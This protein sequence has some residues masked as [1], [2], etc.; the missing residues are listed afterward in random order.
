MKYRKPLKYNKR[1]ALIKELREL[2][3]MLG[4]FI[5]ILAAGMVAFLLWYLLS[6]FILV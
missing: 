6:V 1:I 5:V 2:G 3:I 4:Q